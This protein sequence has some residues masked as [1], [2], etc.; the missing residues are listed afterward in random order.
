MKL[1]VIIIAAVACGLMFYCHHTPHT[2]H[3]TAE[4]LDANQLPRTAECHAQHPTTDANAT[5]TD[6]A[7][8]QATSKPHSALAEQTPDALRR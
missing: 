6:A 4:W 8:D 7:H 1:L 2:T 5:C 3:D